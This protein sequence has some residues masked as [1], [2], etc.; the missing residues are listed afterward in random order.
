MCRAGKNVYS[1]ASKSE[2]PYSLTKFPS[3][4]AY[5]PHVFI[6]FFSQNHKISSQ[7][8]CQIAHFFPPCKC[9]K[10]D[11]SNET[12]NDKM[13]RKRKHMYHPSPVRLIIFLTFLT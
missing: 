9:D 13:T 5:S 2:F 8:A 7:G 12:W 1:P 11:G 10:N 3:S 4:K 6:Y